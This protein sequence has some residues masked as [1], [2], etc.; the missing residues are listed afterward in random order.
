MKKVVAHIAQLLVGLVFLVSAFAKAWGGNAFANLITQYGADWLSVGVPILIAIETILAIMLLLNI[1]AKQASLGSAFFIFGISLVYL[2]GVLAKGIT[3]CGCFGVLHSL[4]MR[5]VPTFIRNIILIGLCLLGFWWGSKQKENAWWKI[6][7]M[8]VLTACSMFICGLDMSKG[9]QLPQIAVLQRQTNQ[10][11]E[12]SALKD[13]LP[14]SSD[15][16]YAVYLFSYTCVFCQ[17]S[18]ANVE[19]YQRIQE[20]DHVYGIAIDNPQ[21]EERFRRIYQPTIPIYNIPEDTMQK[22]V[23][24]LPVL[25][26]IKNGEIVHK[27]V[28]SVISPG[29]NAQ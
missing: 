4:N 13:I 11:I 20:I 25:L 5:P 9:F 15:S 12:Q 17:N 19:Q 27:E 18:F 2:Y 7:I 1:K 10:K 21:G 14:L 6:W 8:I 23:G 28:G 22:L 24:E 3:D 26:L 29:I 16:S